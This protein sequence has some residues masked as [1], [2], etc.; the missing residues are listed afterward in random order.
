[1]KT[2]NQLYKE[3]KSE[4]SFKDWLKAEQV[5]G[6]LKDHEAMFNADG[7]QEEEKKPTTTKTAKVDLGKWNMLAVVSVVS[8]IY[9]LMKVSNSGGM[10]GEPSMEM[11]SE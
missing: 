1:M 3:S 5:E 10:E 9:G 8:L 7:K 4:L 2:A 6:N 11:A